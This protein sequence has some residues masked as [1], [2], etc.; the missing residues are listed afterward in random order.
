MSLVQTQPLLYADR[1]ELESVTLVCDGFG[2]AHHLYRSLDPLVGAYPEFCLVCRSFINDLRKSRVE[3]VVVFDGSVEAAKLQTKLER[4]KA[5]GQ[6]MLTA[7]RHLKS[8]KSLPSACTWQLPPFVSLVLQ[9]VLLVERV[10][11]FQSAG[12]ADQ[13]LASLCHDLGAFAV[14]SNDSDFLIFDVPGFVPFW[15][16]AF[17][18]L[19][20]AGDESAC[21]ALV[22]RRKK[23]A[24]ALGIAPHQLPL[25]AG[26][27]GN[28]WMAANQR[29]QKAMVVATSRK[30]SVKSQHQVVAACQRL[31]LCRLIERLV[32]RSLKRWPAI[33]T[34]IVQTMS[35]RL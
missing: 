17:S 13:D 25:L 3:L 16:L 14:L 30:Q 22:F 19:A 33:C 10:Q 15:S 26:L 21:H 9:Q 6:S 28:D 1:V 29:L 7:A 24:A 18:A 4:Y 27:T 20:P 12:E 5:D 23:V 32:C 35:E 8:S 2:L 31:L 34:C 11:V